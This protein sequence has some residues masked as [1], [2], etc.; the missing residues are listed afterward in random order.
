[1]RPSEQAEYRDI[2]VR[3]I[4]G[5]AQHARSR[6]DPWWDAIE[7]IPEYFDSLVNLSRAP[8]L[9]PDARRVVRRVI[10]Y[11][12]SPLDLMPEFIYGP[13]GFR[14]DLALIV[15]ARDALTAQLG[16]EPFERCGLSEDDPACLRVRERMHIDLDEDILKHLEILLSTDAVAGDEDLARED[17]EV[18]ELTASAGESLPGQGR[19]VMVFAGPGTGKTYR[20]ETELERLLLEEK[21]EPDHVLV[22]TFTNK[23][24]DEL[25]VRIRTRLLEA[26][27]PNP[28]AVLQRLRISTIHA[29]CYSLIGEFHH[30]VLFLKGTFSPMPESQ[31]ILF[32]FRHG[33]GALHLKDIYAAWKE[34]RR[35]AGRR[36]P[37]DLFHFYSYVGT[38]YDFLSEDVMSG[39]EEALRL[40]Y[41]E[42]LHEDEPA[43]V[44]ER[45]VKTYPMYWRLVQ[46]EGFLDHSM[47]LAYAEALLDDPQVR[48][49]VQ[50]RYR[51]LLV[52][53]YQDTNPIQ[54]R[55]FRAIAGSSGRL[56]AVGDDDQSIYAFRGADVRNAVEFLDRWPGAVKETLEENRRSTRAIVDATQALIA[57]NRRR[58]P[59]HLHTKN[60]E[61]ERPWRLSAPLEELPEQLAL[62]LSELRKGGTIERWSDV[63]LLFRGMTRRVPNYLAAL[64]EKDVPAV[65]VGDRHFLQRPVVSGLMGVLDM[66][67]GDAEKITMRKRKH[68]PFFEA[69]G[70]TDRGKMLEAVC[71]WHERF[72]AGGYDTLL[73]LFYGILNETGAIAVP[74]C[75][76]DLGRFSAFLAEAESQ[77]RSPHL[78]KRLGWFLGYA[79]AAGDS[80]AGPEQP[81]KDAVQIMTIHKSKGLQFPIVVIA[82]M[83][84]GVIPAEF[85]EDARTQLRRELAGVQPWLDVEEEERR[86]V[87]VAATRAESLV[88]LLTSAENPSR[89]LEELPSRRVETAAVGGVRE[90]P[91]GA[92][93]PRR[94]SVVP[95]HVTH[96]QVYNYRFCPKRHLLEDRF[97]F[98]GR[99]IAPL[100]AGQSLH[101]ALEIFH[102]LA[103]EGASMPEDRLGRIFERSW[104]QPRETK[105][106]RAEAEQLLGVFKTYAHWYE[107]E[108]D[109]M[110]IVDIERPF[111]VAEPSAVLTGK[112]DLLREHG[113]ALEIVEFKFHKNPM[114][115]D[116]PRRQL[117]HYSL[118]C[119]ADRPELVVHYLRE[120][121][122]ETFSRREPELVRAE[123]AETFAGMTRG[124]FAPAPERQ[125]CR[126]CPVRFACCDSAAQGGE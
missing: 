14:E 2:L 60:P 40:R 126:L 72:H 49:R 28:D 105:A 88:V 1:M 84:E 27:L 32:L 97:G 54:D 106:A 24:A 94:R 68:R 30:H 76:A 50:A 115:P 64:A 117:D 95:L 99:A 59:K 63:A 108:R 90:F 26:H 39:F 122:Q 81:P 12:I 116:Y 82:D 96:G 52:D 43:R 65:V 25:R 103:R 71:E 8:S 48:R 34:E 75:L 46:D 45:I 29:F 74:E 118:S 123:L 87:Y 111:Y 86:V 114:L 69:L 91:A 62:L 21:V 4:A 124:D 18:Q 109:G 98:A 44:D 57:H 9:S 113:G 125:R 6:D 20:I 3:E 31:R 93:G 78:G 55:I 36:A 10:K 92:Y 42:I 119:C 13:D 19:H 56:F 66:I 73:D 38:V 104:V 102:R 16:S 83:V 101:R 41:L 120:N 58:E 37:V 100:R 70:W 110:N 7:R 77:I 5:W 17:L 22:T 112:I 11:L 61:G 15:M 85:P 80:Y 89:F 35:S 67:A 33:P 51:H 79:A 107:S 23:A 47:V 53:E 121:R